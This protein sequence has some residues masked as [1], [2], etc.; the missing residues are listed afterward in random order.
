ML[1]LQLW[2]DFES[3]D[4]FKTDGPNQGTDRWEGEDH[5]GYLGP[6]GQGSRLTRQAW[7]WNEACPED[8]PDT[9]EERHATGSRLPIDK[10]MLE[11]MQD[12][13]ECVA[14]SGRQVVKQLGVQEKHQRFY[15]KDPLTGQLPEVTHKLKFD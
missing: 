7:M 2:N 10:T 6:I 9:P 4:S 1:V 12:L 8:W 14:A 3:N 13:E 5:G 11:R 15:K